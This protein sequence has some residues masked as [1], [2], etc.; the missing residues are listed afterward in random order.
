MT[1]SMQYDINKVRESFPVLKDVYYLNMGTYG[2]IP[3]PALKKF[4]NMQ[5][6][7]EHGFRRGSK[8]NPWTKTQETKERIADLIGATPDEVAFTR[9]AT[10]GINLVLSGIDWQPGDEVIT[11]A[12]EHEAMNHPLLYLQKTKG[13]KAR[14]IEVS[15]EPD[16]MIERIE[17]VFGPRTRLI[18]MI[19]AG[20]AALLLV[21]DLVVR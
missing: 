12:Q 16:V 8:E 11:T 2:V 21:I 20:I 7:S 17:A 3:E 19:I 5:I 15:P 6:E 1:G 13:I 18:A 4:I 14:F 10:D 9:N